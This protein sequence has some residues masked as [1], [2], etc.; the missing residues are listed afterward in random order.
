MDCLISSIVFENE[1]KKEEDL[2]VEKLFRE[3][4]GEE[5]ILV[6]EQDMLIHCVDFQIGGKSK[7]EYPT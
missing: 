4:N 2:V 7:Y 5:T 3:S 6:A 1:Q